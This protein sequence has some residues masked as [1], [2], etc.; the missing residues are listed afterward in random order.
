VLAQ[1]HFS[2]LSTRGF[3]GA[4]DFALIAGGILTGDVPKPII[5]CALGPTLGNFGVQGMLADSGM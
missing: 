2:N 3:V 1:S 5:V 4:G